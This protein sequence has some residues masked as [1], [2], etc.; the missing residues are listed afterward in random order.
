MI[1]GNLEPKTSKEGKPYFNLVMN[2]PFIK[3]QN[4]YVAANGNKTTE[5]SPDFN[6]FLS[7]NKCGAIWKKKSNKGEDYLSGSIFCLGMPGNRIGFAVFK[8]K[9]EKLKDEKGQPVNLVVIS[10]GD[11]KDSDSLEEHAP[12]T[13]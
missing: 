9:D 1:V 3:E 11:K 2:I 12:E 4:F 5:N 7:G 8:S 6:I 13:F 10:E